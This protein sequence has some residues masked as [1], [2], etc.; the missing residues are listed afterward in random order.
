[1]AMV[2]LLNDDTYRWVCATINVSSFRQK[3]QGA[4]LNE[5]SISEAHSGRAS[6]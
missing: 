6:L 5:E 2:V 4:Q 1:M 3:E